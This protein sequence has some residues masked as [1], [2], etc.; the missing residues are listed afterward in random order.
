[1][2]FIYTGTDQPRVSSLQFTASEIYATVDDVKY[3]WLLPGRVYNGYTTEVIATSG[4]SPLLKI[5]YGGV[6]HYLKEGT[7]AA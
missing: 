4:V 6:L 3:E 2:K 5:T 7:R 1:M